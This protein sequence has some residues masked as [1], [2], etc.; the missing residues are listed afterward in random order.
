MSVRKIV[1]T[2]NN[3]DLTMKLDPPI[4]FE[5]GVEYE[6]ALNGIYTSYSWL[7]VNAKNNIFKYYYKETTKI[8]YI[9]EGSYELR[10][11]IKEI[12]K[13]LK[14]NGDVK[15]DSNNEQIIR[16]EGNPSTYK[17]SVFIKDISY[18]VDFSCD[19]SVGSIF[20][21]NK[22]ILDV[23]FHISD[24]TVK[25]NPVNTVL[26]HCDLA[27]GN[28]Y[29]DKEAKIIYEFKSKVPQGYDIIENPT[30]IIYVQIQHF[31]DEKCQR[32]RTWLTDQDLQ[33]I[34][35]RSENITISLLI[36]Q[37]GFQ[38]DLVL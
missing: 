21:F 32:I 22:K 16:I 10:L 18:R 38:K 37:C 4:L 9:S 12:E 15:K 29:N 36:K 11:L 23:G 2:G 3:S 7:N 30:N 13:H 33:P 35:L 20:G 25:I 5:K 28:D 19:N 1:F 24:E 27:S 26:V 17:S 34:D 31:D 14:L 6:V 8:I